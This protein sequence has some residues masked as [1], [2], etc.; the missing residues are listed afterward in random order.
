MKKKLLI[1]IW[2]PRREMLS[3]DSAFHFLAVFHGNHESDLGS[4]SASYE[5][6][7]QKVQSHPYGTGYDLR[8]SGRDQTWLRK[9]HLS[10]HGLDS[11]IRQVI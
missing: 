7:K 2:A 6:K 8:D 1:T 4:A 3:G 9:V 11:D 5:Q 10:A